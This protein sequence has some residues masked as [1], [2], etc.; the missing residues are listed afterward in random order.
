MLRPLPVPGSLDM[1]NVQVA[2]LAGTWQTL[3]GPV[4]VTFLYLKAA[5]ELTLVKLLL[6]TRHF[7]FEISFSPLVVLIRYKINFPKVIWLRRGFGWVKALALS[8]T[9]PPGFYYWGS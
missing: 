5:E 2:S 8:V 9:C 6:N 1:K 7:K 4:S 3:H